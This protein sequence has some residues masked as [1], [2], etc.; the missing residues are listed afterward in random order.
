[1]S[2]QEQRSGGPNVGWPR[3]MAATVL[4]SGLVVVVAE[5]TSLLFFV[6]VVLVG[7]GSYGI[8]YGSRKGRT[9]PR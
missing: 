2:N 8:V 9:D 1:M 6:G 3:W 5:T 4:L 7:F